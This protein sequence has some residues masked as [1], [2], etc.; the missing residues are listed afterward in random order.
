MEEFEEAAAV[1]VAAANAVYTLTAQTL[2]GT[3]PLVFPLMALEVA[4][5]LA[6]F[7]AYE[8]TLAASVRL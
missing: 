4:G 5:I 3:A 8:A 7:A 1:A 2:E 6:G